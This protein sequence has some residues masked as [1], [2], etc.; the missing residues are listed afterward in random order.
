MTWTEYRDQ[1]LRP[2][3]F[4][5]EQPDA[6]FHTET[7]AYFAPH[8]TVRIGGHLVEHWQILA[9]MGL[10]PKDGRDESRRQD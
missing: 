2:A 9:A 7:A 3:G 6:Y 4:K 8:N 5:Y 10:A 1:I